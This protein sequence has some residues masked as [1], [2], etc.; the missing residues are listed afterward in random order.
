MMILKMGINNKEICWDYST[1]NIETWLNSVV[2][3]GNFIGNKIDIC[4]PKRSPMKLLAPLKVGMVQLV[5]V[6]SG[7]I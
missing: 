1:T 6:P 7:C 4:L 5:M 2:S 3:D